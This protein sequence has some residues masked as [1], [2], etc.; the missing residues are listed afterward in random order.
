M[1]V[2]ETITLRAGYHG[3]QGLYGVLPDR[4]VVGK[5][6]GGGVPIGAVCG[7]IALSEPM[8]D[9][10]IDQFIATAQAVLTGMFAD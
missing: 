9:A 1:I 5:M 8:T 6:I 4:T 2:D 7:R 3:M 10:D